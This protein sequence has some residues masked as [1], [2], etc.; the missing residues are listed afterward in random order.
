MKNVKEY[1]SKPDYFIEAFKRKLRDIGKFQLKQGIPFSLFQ[2]VMINHK[3]KI[4]KIL[5]TYKIRTRDKVI[6]LIVEPSGK[7]SV[8]N[9]DLMMFIT[10]KA[11]ENK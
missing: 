11:N 3:E 10:K 4:N 9:Q 7:P 8:P 2:A 1:E 6:R 5:K